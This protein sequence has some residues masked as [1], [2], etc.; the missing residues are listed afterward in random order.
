VFHCY[1]ENVAFAS[2]LRAINFL[3]SI[4]GT[5]T[6]KNAELVRTVAAEVPLEQIMV[7]T[8]APFL[9]PVPYRGKRNEPSFMV[10]TVK[11]IAECRGISFEEFARVT[12][13]NA[14]RLFKL[15]RP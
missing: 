11:K 12:T 9:A 4:P 3:I 1:A 7:E 10:E 2:R 8:D 14:V 13:E 6:F 5:V 15:P